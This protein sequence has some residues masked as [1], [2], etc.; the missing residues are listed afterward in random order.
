M[1]NRI[2]LI[3]FETHEDNISALVDNGGGTSW[4]EFNIRDFSKWLKEFEPM[5]FNACIQEHIE[6]YTHSGGGSIRKIKGFDFVFFCD[7][8]Q[9]HEIIE[10]FIRQ[11]Q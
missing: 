4:T 11:K 2:N 6:D 7:V 8:F 5:V 10:D 3:E 1:Y 9:S